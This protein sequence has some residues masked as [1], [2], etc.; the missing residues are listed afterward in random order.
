MTIDINAG[1]RVREVSKITR[2]RKYIA[3]MMSDSLQN[4]P[5]ASGSCYMPVDALFELKDELKKQ[6]PHVS[7]TSMFTKLTAQALVENPLVNSALI[8]GE[9]FYVYDS[10]NINIGIGLEDGI[11][12]CVIKECQDKNIFEISD[13]LHENIGLLKEKK[14]SMD[15]MMGST[16]TI[17]NIGMFGA[18]QATS[19]LTP[20]ET[21]I[22]AIGAIYKRLCV[23][24][25]DT[26][27]I[28][29]LCCFSIT[30]NHAAI[31]GIHGAH[32]TMSLR[33]LLK[34]PAQYMGL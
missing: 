8:N 20:P 17:S 31:D 15:K 11:M 26:T 1:K 27:S 14:L 9:D 7:L 4:Y 25:D 34:D 22:L 23:N 21:G 5:Q 2:P 16:F 18:E 28:R 24:D 13:E 19:I 29:R 30:I 3:G 6:D 10:V 12:P 32:F 33:R